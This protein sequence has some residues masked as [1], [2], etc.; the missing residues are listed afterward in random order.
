MSILFILLFSAAHGHIK[1]TDFGLSE[2]DHKITLAEIL[3]TPRVQKQATYFTFESISPITKLNSESNN[4]CTNNQQRTP[5]QILSLTSNIDFNDCINSSSIISPEIVRRGRINAASCTD[6][7][8]LSTFSIRHDYSKFNPNQKDDDDDCVFEDTEQE[9]QFFETSSRSRNKP[10]LKRNNGKLNLV[11]NK[12]TPLKWSKTSSFS[13]VQKKSK[14]ISK[15]S[16]MTKKRTILKSISM[17]DV[18]HSSA[19]NQSIQSS[20]ILD[21]YSPKTGLTNIFDTVKLIDENNL[22]KLTKYSTAQNLTMPYQNKRISLSP[23]SANEEKNFNML[24]PTARCTN[25]VSILV[26]HDENKNNNCLLFF[27]FICIFL[28][29]STSLSF[30]SNLELNIILFTTREKVI[31]IQNTENN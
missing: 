12:V 10:K 4:N 26:N 6:S 2:I 13:G 8:N 22:A 16:G 30:L 21:N 7:Q 24:S 11:Q 28:A 14:L 3:P 31:F 1:L 17:L 23:I 25:T 5:G 9:Q 27:L 19:S 29:H 18:S 20:F 15:P